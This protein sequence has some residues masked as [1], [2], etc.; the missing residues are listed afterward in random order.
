M[1]QSRPYLERRTD[2][3]G[4]DHYEETNSV[5]PACAE[6]IAEAFADALQQLTH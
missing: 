3:W 6:K 4:E 2:M 5:G 1:N